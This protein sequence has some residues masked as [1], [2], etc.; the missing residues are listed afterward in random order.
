[1]REKITKYLIEVCHM[2]AE[3]VAN[4]QLS[5]LLS[6]VEMKDITMYNEFKLGLR[7]EG[8]II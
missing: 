6:F 2:N 1:M 4:L 7:K 8:W 5:K 3:T